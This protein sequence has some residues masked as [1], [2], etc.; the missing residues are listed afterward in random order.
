MVLTQDETIV[1]QQLLPKLARAL[2][3]VP[4]AEDL[5]AAWHCAFDPATP[6]RVKG[7]L[8]GALAYFVLPVDAI[9]DFIPVI[10]FSD[11][12]TVLATAITAVRTHITGKHRQRARDTL[13]RLKQGERIAG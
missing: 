13:E 11:D 12:L 7:I 3:Q 9:P 10:G 4:F 6:L 8:V 1:R 5:L 2:A